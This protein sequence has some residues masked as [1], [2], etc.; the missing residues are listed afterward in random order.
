MASPGLHPALCIARASISKESAPNK[1]KYSKDFC[2]TFKKVA[3][4]PFIEKY[5]RVV[6]WLLKLV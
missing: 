4:C 5:K 1:S 2:L 3:F 6:N